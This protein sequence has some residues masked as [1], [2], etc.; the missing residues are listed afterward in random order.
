MATVLGDDGYVSCTSLEDSSRIG[1]QFG[2]NSAFSIN[3][4]MA[5]TQSV[6]RLVPGCTGAFLGFCNYQTK[7]VIENANANITG[8]EMLNADCVLELSA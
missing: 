6:M 2:F 4:P 7:R 3:D 1:S 8:K 5:F